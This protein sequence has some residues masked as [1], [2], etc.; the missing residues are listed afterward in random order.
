MNKGGNPELQP[1]N[2]DD[3]LDRPATLKEL[4]ISLNLSSDS[5]M[6]ARLPVEEQRTGAGG[7]ITK[8]DNTAS[9]SAPVEYT[10]N[11]VESILKN[12]IGRTYTLLK[13]FITYGRSIIIHRHING[14]WGC[15]GATG[16]IFLNGYSLNY[17]K[18]ISAYK[19]QGK[20]GANIEAEQRYR[21]VN[22]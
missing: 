19:R 17:R 20:T 22:S 18:R 1:I 13:R 21:F 15:F 10:Q 9:I 2:H 16:A 8:E 7:V 11:G 5:Q 3:K 14:I 12:Y 4:D 6:L